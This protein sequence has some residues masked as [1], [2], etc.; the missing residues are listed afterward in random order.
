MA[1]QAMAEEPFVFSGTVATANGL[2]VSVYPSLVAVEPLWR[3][4]ETRAV[5]TP[6][7]RFEWIAGYC[8]AGFDLPDTI[9]ILAVMDGNKPVALAPF[10]VSR[11]FGIKL[12]Q[13]VGMPISNMDA[14]LYDPTYAE[15]LT[16]ELLRDAFGAL[17][18]V[19]AD[20]VSFH[21]FVPLWQGQPNLLMGLP[22]VPAPNNLYLGE[23]DALDAEFIEE[24]LP[25]K[26]R[27]NIRRSKRR[28]T[29]GYG[30]LSVRA[31]GSADEIE[32]MHAAFL[33]QRGKR[34]RAMGVANI[35]AAPAFQSHFRNLAIASLGQEYPV[36]R[37]HALYAGDEI[38]ATSLGVCTPTHYSQYINSTTIGS[39]SKYSLMGV[40]LS[41][42][43]DQLRSE[44][45]TSFD[46]GLGDF[47]YK[48]DW[49]AATTVYDSLLPVSPLGTLTAPVLLGARSAKRAIK[50]TPTLWTIAR[51]VLA[52]KTR[53][54]GRG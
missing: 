42:L 39:A 41:A 7:Q 38:L 16:P 12:A 25:H 15:R 14:I 33:D 40:M 36:F 19:G 51:S 4:L 54:L 44:G 13:I 32:A 48:T 8:A 34:F 2:T 10:G 23:L 28:L 17:R 6:Y 1:V 20:I 27:T 35:F 50:Q 26:R 5:L 21:S 3:D 49:T 53:L 43:L 46:M 45:Y 52:I 47:D 24:A 22:H 9:A 29:E 18:R 30:E 37:Y 11:R 31:A